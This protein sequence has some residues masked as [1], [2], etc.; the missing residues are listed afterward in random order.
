MCS[1]T[2]LALVIHEIRDIV[3]MPPPSPCPHILRLPVILPPR[4]H[5]ADI[6]KIPAAE[7]FRSFKS[8]LP[9]MRAAI[10]GER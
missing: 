9:A 7:F 2:P 6:V 10:H 5:G 3:R 1:V 4:N 8:A